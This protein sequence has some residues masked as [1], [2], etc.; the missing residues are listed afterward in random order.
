MIWPLVIIL[1]VL[2]WGLLHILGL[3]LTPTLTIPDSFSY[4]QMA[5][6]LKDFKWEGFWTGWFWPLY[7][8]IIAIFSTI[9]ENDYLVGKGV[10]VLL[11][12]WGW[13]ILAQIWKRYLNELYCI[14]L[15]ILYGLSSSLL[16]YKVNILSENL[17][18]PLFLL[19]VLLLHKFLEGQRSLNVFKIGLTIGLMYLTRSEAFIYLWSVVVLFFLL[20]TIRFLNFSEVARSFLLL[21]LWFWIIASPYVY[22]L[23]TITW[24]RWLTNKWASNIRQAMMRG[25]E[26]MDD[27]GFEKAVGELDE[28]KTKLISGFVWWLKYDKAAEDYNIKDYIM[29]DPGWFLNTVK[30]N[31]KKL[32]LQIIPDMIDGNIKGF[33]KDLHYPFA[34]KFPFLFLLYFPFVFII[35]GVWKMLWKREINLIISVLPLFLTASL[36]FT[37]FFVLERY[38]I[39]F[40]PLA[41]IVMLY[42]CQNLFYKDG[43]VQITKFIILSGIL[44]LIQWIWFWYTY[45]TWTDKSFVIKKTTGEWLKANKERLF[46]WKQNLKIMERWP[47]VTYYSGEKERWLTPYTDNISDI[48]TYAKANNIDI[49][50]VDTLDFLT[51]R[52]QLKTLLLSNWKFW[53]LKVISTFNKD[54]QKVILY[55]FIY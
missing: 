17:Y 36:F 3:S 10:N 40:L 25:V 30:Q 42:G 8:L 45:H 47:I 33:S 29:K 12:M 27:D 49:L 22:Y 26:H 11:M 48:V 37:L 43:K 50:V 46:P 38:F 54:G 1:W 32:Y 2:V 31:Q 9:W 52:P 55:K 51:Y 16:Y 53:G 44:V 41:F 6:Y 34:Q 15:L 39:V 20:G 13:Y 4:L 5:S 24:E 35:Y 23:H 18:I 7:S 28:T 21:I 19:L 14:A